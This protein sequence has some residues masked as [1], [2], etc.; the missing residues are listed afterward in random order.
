MLYR[1]QQRSSLAANLSDY[2]HLLLSYDT[3]NG[4][5]AN[6]GKSADECLENGVKS[7]LAR[8]LQPVTRSFSK[9]AEAGRINCIQRDQAQAEAQ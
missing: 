4:N 7:K 3:V 1:K 8:P 5:D 6:D 9:P 2:E